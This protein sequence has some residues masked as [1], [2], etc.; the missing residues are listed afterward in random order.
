LATTRVR[1]EIP[2]AGLAVL[3]GPPGSGNS[4]MALDHTFRI[5]QERPVLY[6]AADR[7]PGYAARKLAWCEL[8][9]RG[10]GRA[11]FLPHAVN[12]LDAVDTAALIQAAEPIRPALI[13]IDTLSRE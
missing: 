3:Y 12:L 1:G 8:H 9:K 11:Y 7:A 10:P 6:V 5:A 4:F 13:V 2:A